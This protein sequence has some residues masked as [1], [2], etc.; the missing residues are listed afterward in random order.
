[1]SKKSTKK[2]KALVKKTVTTDDIFSFALNNTVRMIGLKQGEKFYP[3]WYDDS[4][5]FYPPKK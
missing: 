4:H 1:M 2:P 5:K 3:V